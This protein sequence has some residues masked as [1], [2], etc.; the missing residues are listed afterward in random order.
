MQIVPRGFCP[1]LELKEIFSKG[2]FRGIQSLSVQPPERIPCTYSSP[3]RFA[4]MSV[5]LGSFSALPSLA[6]N[7][8]NSIRSDL[9]IPNKHPL[10]LD[11]GKQ[12]ECHVYAVRIS[13]Y[14]V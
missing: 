1:Y 11:F 14:I 6:R 8:S 2:G 7:N 13:D 10:F 5:W 9:N 12:F 3:V 4:K